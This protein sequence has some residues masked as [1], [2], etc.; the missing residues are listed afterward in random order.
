MTT[1]TAVEKEVWVRGGFGE[2]AT[3]E[4]KEGAHEV[5]DGTRN[6]TRTLGRPESDENGGAMTISDGEERRRWWGTSVAKR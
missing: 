2:T 5:G 6:M 1:A 3:P 4:E